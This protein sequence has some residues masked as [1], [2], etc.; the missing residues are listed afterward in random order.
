ME[1]FKPDAEKND[2]GNVKAVVCRV[3]GL[4][5]AVTWLE[6]TVLC[7]FPEDAVD[8]LFEEITCLLKAA[9]EEH[10]PITFSAVTFIDPLPNYMYISLRYIAIVYSSKG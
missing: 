4:S 10:T 5:K 7:L 6:V 3:Y 2:S 8:M 9:L 1:A